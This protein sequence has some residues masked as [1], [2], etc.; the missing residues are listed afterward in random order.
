MISLC[1]CFLGGF[2]PAGDLVVVVVV[3]VA[4]HNENVM[5]TL[6]LF[7]SIMI[8]TTSPYSQHDDDMSVLL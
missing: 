8:R 4:A 5:I 1:F 2:F 6:V 3:V 7:R